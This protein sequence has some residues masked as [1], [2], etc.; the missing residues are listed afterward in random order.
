LRDRGA[1]LATNCV[2][3]AIEFANAFA[4]EHLLLA[5]A[6]PALVASRA[7]NA[8]TI[9][10]GATSSVSF[11]DY[12]TGANHVLPTR[13]TARFFSGLSVLDFMRWTTVQSVDRDAAARLAEDV[14]IFAKAE[15]LPA[16]AAAAQEWGRV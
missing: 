16:H 3:E 5:C 13:G 1:L 11:G 9:F 15:G 10:L 7:R 2:T 14:G 4:P 12:M 6:D 8:G